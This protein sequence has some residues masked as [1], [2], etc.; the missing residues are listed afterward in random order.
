M[1]DLHSLFKQWCKQ[2]KRSGG[3]LIGGSVREFLDWLDEKLKE[4][5]QKE[6]T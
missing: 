4:R 5:T 6:K 2:T 1:I 3:V